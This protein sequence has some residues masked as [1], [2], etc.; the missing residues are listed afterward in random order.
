MEFDFESFT[1]IEVFLGLLIKFGIIN[2]M[3]EF[4]DPV[5][6]GIATVIIVPLL[7]IAKFALDALNW[8][9]GRPRVVGTTTRE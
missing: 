5:L 4:L 3:I 1:E 7:W 2:K 8:A 6:R 9:V